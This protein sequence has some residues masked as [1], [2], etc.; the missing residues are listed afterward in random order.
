[1]DGDRLRP[2]GSKP[3]GV[4]EAFFEKMCTQ[5]HLLNYRRYLDVVRINASIKRH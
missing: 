5:T 2:S 1:M 3:R 4:W